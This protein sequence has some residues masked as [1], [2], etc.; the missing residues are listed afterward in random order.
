MGNAAE[1][2]HPSIRSPN[3]FHPSS[4]T[5]LFLNV[6]TFLLLSIEG[7]NTEKACGRGY[8]HGTVQG[9]RKNSGDRDDR[10][11]RGTSSIK[12][13]CSGWRE[14]EPSSVGSQILLHSLLTEAPLHLRHGK[15]PGMIHILLDIEPLA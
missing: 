4:T 2:K 5:L 10:L 7:F 1:K 9:S 14:I 3:T 15:Q 8:I 6:S 13:S 11:S 12:S